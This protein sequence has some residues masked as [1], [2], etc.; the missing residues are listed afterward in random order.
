MTKTHQECITYASLC[1]SNCACLSMSRWRSCSHRLTSYTIDSTPY[2]VRY[3]VQA[4]SL[5]SVQKIVTHARTHTSSHIRSTYHTHTHTHIRSIHIQVSLDVRADIRG[6][7]DHGR[8]M[9][10]SPEKYQACTNWHAQPMQG[11]WSV[12]PSCNIAWW[13]TISMSRSYNG[14]VSNCL[15]FD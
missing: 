7:I 3:I 4:F 15:V 6:C 12:L 2:R 8:W 13:I 1:V 9:Q 14:N 10:Y 11:R 5:C